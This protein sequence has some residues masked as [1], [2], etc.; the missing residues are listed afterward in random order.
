MWLFL[1][2]SVTCT[3]VA[4]LVGV[5]LQRRAGHQ[6]AAALAAADRVLEGAAGE[7]QAHG[8]PA[9]TAVSGRAARRP[10]IGDAAT[11][12]VVI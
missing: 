4:M 5:M 3:V 11:P 1:L 12:T 10:G 7:H 9:T 2:C 8:R 6:A